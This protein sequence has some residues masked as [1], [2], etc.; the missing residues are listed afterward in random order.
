MCH[1][2]SV[3]LLLLVAAAYGDNCVS[4]D[5][6]VETSILEPMRQILSSYSVV[7]IRSVNLS[8]RFASVSGED[9]QIGNLT[10]FA[11]IP[12]ESASRICHST[13][14]T[15]TTFV[16]I[17][18]MKDFQVSFGNFIL[19]GPIFSIGGDRM[20]TRISNAVFT[21]SISIIR[22]SES[23]C[24]AHLNYITVNDIGYITPNF[25]P[26]SIVNRLANV[27]LGYIIFPAFKMFNLFDNLYSYLNQ[28]LLSIG[29]PLITDVSHELCGY[30]KNFR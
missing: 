10:S 17:L 26:L 8:F 3:V 18:T 6:K 13:D 28:E 30:Y 1:T 5:A 9:G 7:A 25:F 23:E 29:N 22:S 11:L 20:S 21:C 16:G 14:G 15:N 2:V 4:G 19:S 12:T 27:L 24:H